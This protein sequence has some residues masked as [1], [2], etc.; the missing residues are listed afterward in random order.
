[1]ILDWQAGRVLLHP[2]WRTTH[3]CDGK[4]SQEQIYIDGTP[5]LFV[6]KEIEP[7]HSSTYRIKI[8][9]SLQISD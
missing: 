6:N 9:R 1:M 4:A 7:T 8:H 5:I 2:P 3:S